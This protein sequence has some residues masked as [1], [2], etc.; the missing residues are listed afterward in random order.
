M[1]SFDA[2]GTNPREVVVTTA[3]I[4]SKYHWF[5]WAKTGLQKLPTLNHVLHSV[6]IPGGGAVSEFTLYYTETIHGVPGRYTVGTSVKGIIDLTKGPSHPELEQGGIWNVAGAMNK[7]LVDCG[8]M[9]EP[10]LNA[11]RLPG[12]FYIELHTPQSKNSSHFALVQ[13]PVC[14]VRYFNLIFG[15][16]PVRF[17]FAA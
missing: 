17:L 13:D 7:R 11:S 12:E 9:K 10:M 8:E 14:I 6:E 16:N 5:D 3:G 1:T 4:F 15:T 2:T